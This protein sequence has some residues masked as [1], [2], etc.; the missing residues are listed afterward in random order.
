VSEISDMPRIPPEL[1]AS[2]RPKGDDP[3][4]QLGQASAISG[5]DE[6]GC[7]EWTVLYEYR[8]DSEGSR[9]SYSG[10]LSSGQVVEALKHDNW[11]LRVGSGGPSFSQRRRDGVDYVE[12]DRFGF[13]GTEPVVYS[14][15]FH[16]I[17][18]PQFD[19]SE[20]FRLFHNL[21]HDRHNDRYVHID[22][23]GR[24][25]IVVEVAP[26][27][28]RVL[29]R[30]LRQYMAA[31]QLTLVLVFDHHSNADVDAE[32]AKLA[33]PSMQVVTPDRNYSFR[34]GEVMGQSFSRLIGKK[35]IAP[36]PIEKS[37]V[38]PYEAGQRDRYAE[39]VIEVGEDGL[40]IFHS[41]DPEDLANYFGANESAPHYLTPVWFK[42]DVLVKYYNDPSKYSVEDGYLRCGS[43]WGL[44]M[45]NNPADHV[46]VYL[47][48]LGRDLDHEEQ[49]Y[50]KLFNVTSG[51]RQPSDT[52][53]QRAFHAQFADPSAPDL[54][55]K[56]NYT[57]LNEAWAKEFGWPIFRPLHEADAHILPQLHVPITETLSE[58]EVQVL[59]L[60]KLLI[61]SLN[62]AE[63]KRACSG[64]QSDEKGISKFKRYLEDK[65]YPNSD[66]DIGLLRTLQ[67]LRSSGAVHAKGKNFDKIRMRVGLDV[68]NP[69]DVFRGLMSQVNQMLTDLFAYFVPARE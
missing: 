63:L 50:W 21:Y 41:C 35:I 54:L 33:F 1:A 8:S 12:Y 20:E 52:N 68:D 36:P 47:G 37:G 66:R 48:D 57:L 10:L 32:E 58:F 42:R 14:R 56:Q 59:F 43:L 7:G 65:R 45:D 4:T 38:W 39:F 44:R 6:L 27:R 61:D 53:F 11:G 5:I 18:P 55:F 19:L 23:R 29:T 40:P 15:D 31:R 51:G 17:K 49:I 16:G 34:V 46:V 13:D 24:E 26:G 25:T 67:D 62:E 69:K 3:M 9:C 30:F 28:V 22:D 60:V 64:G 2:R